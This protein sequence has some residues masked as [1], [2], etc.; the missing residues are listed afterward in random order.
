MGTGLGLSI[1]KRLVGLMG[2]TLSFASE[3]AKGTVFRF[4]IPF[5]TS[6]S[7]GETKPEGFSLRQAA[8]LGLAVLVVEDDRVSRLALTRALEA[9]GCDV[10]T[11]GDGEAALETL[12][13]GSYDVVFMDRQLPR[14]DGVEATKAI[15][16]GDAGSANRRVHVVALTAATMKDEKESFLKAE[17][18]DYLAKPVDF[19][20]LY[21]ALQRF[22]AK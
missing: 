1:I 19:R 5:E 18:D 22:G 9:F 2:G 15:R 21:S 13:A 17:I 12:A 4:S 6:S 11:A 3:R 10:A 8:P 16:R 20:Q 7:T 14:M